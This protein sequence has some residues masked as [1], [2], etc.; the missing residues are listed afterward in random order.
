MKGKLIDRLVAAGVFLLSLVVYLRTMAETLPFWDSG[1]FI[2]SVLHL[3]VM[4]PPGAPFY[5]LVGRFFTFFAPLFAA[6]TD[7][8]A[9][10]AVNLVSALVSAAT[11]L[12]THLTIVRLVRVW[13]G[14]PAGWS[15]GDRIAANAGGAVG[16]LAF[17][18]TDSF[19]FNAVEAE[20]YAF[21]MLFT[22]AVV[23][24]ALVWREATI[25]EEAELRARGEHPFGLRADRYLLIIAYLFGLAIGVHLL[26][27]LAVF[28]V[29]LIVFFTKFD[30]EDFTPVQRGVRILA[31]GVAGA[32]AFF[33]V[34][35]GV[36]QWLPS[37]AGASGVPGLFVIAVIAAVAGAVWWTQRARKPIANLFAL[38][39]MLV[40]VGYSTYGVI[41]LRAAAD[42]PIEL[43]DPETADRFVS[44]LKREQY[45]ST[46]LLRGPNLGTGYRTDVTFP[47][48]WSMEG[49]HIDVYRRYDSD[50]EFFLQYQLGHMYW[51]Y[52]FWNF[53][54][55]AGDAQDAPWITGLA[56]ESETS[57]TTYESISERMARNVYFGLPLLLGLLGMAF[58]FSRDWRRALAVLALF[59][60]MGVG[61]VIY[62][63]QTPNQPRE[64]DYSYVASF[65]AFT[66]WVG[67]GATGLVEAV[68]SAL[69]KRRP[70][71]VRAAALGV[72]GVTL[73]AAPAILLA[74]NYDD[75][76]RSGNRLPTDF[77]WNLLQSTDPNAILFTN[78]DNDTYP[79]W[80]LQ[81]VMHIRRDVRVV[82]LSLLNT[83]WYVLQL[84]NQ[85]SRDSAPLPMA[86]TDAQI[87]QLVPMLEY[88]PREFSLP[89]PD[90][91][92]I[93]W[94]L[95]GQP[96]PYG[97][98][99]R[100]LFIADLAVLD[101]LSANAADG[102]SRPIYFSSTVAESSE[103]GLQ[104]FFR[105]DGLARRVMP[106]ETGG[107]VDG[108]VDPA[109]FRERLERY[110]FRG[111]A[112]RGVYY[113]ENA[114]GLADV[115]N[116]TLAT[117]ASHLAAE[118]DSALAAAT[119]RR[120]TTEIDPEV[121]PPSFYSSVVVAQALG[122]SGD[123]AAMTAMIA[124]AEREAISLLS[125]ATTEQQQ[126]RALQYIRI[127][128]AAYLQAGAFDAASAFYDRLAT[129]VGDPT[130]RMS[131][132]AIRAQ[133]ESMSVPVAA[134]S[135]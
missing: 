43:N 121:I 29:A 22:A 25:E 19:W 53:A 85:W 75:H 48:R 119:L 28:F 128:Q 66:L 24:L 46:P 91:G 96:S 49:S 124:P 73:L 97:G 72:A 23:W 62:L 39:L 59:L 14:V 126:S 116:R 45:G 108:A 63:N 134:D 58:H 6:V 18:F 87:G 113:D 86:M 11:V 110:R 65:F 64:R 34:Y 3:E 61:I 13:K 44:Y 129:A 17:A 132:D 16:A 122:A 55:R 77:A 10:F 103:L 2:A 36:I 37:M 42:P 130:I 102:W 99:I 111:L 79:L 120:L 21:S 38:A 12:L 35:P 98:N 133:A 115:Y 9:A 76:D 15:A 31:T 104:P 33:V 8:P 92:A 80:Y 94:T 71:L 82:N 40:V 78:G 106:Y 51:R 125:S 57:G 135:Q 93:R 109:V 74:Q 88:Q 41:F 60:I 26:N 1:E 52:F 4:H 89:T 20:V 90:G 54:G 84:R 47:R 83:D 5:I 105:N 67:I 32:L 114:R 81:E 107:G 100:A 70:A 127:L 118:G 27:L 7:E 117:V 68:E 95:S 101:I 112:D 56:G 50:L 69:A 30:R 123:E 131:S